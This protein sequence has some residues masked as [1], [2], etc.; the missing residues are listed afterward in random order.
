MQSAEGGACSRQDSL[1]SPGFGAAEIIAWIIASGA[2]RLLAP[3]H[4]RYQRNLQQGSKHGAHN[5]YSRHGMSTLLP[6]G[7]T[8]HDRFLGVHQSSTWCFSTGK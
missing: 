4:A 6:I 3:V 5:L 1:P 7:L 8:L 2:V